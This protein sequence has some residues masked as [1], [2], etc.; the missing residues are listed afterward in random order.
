M[1]KSHSLKRPACSVRELLL[2]Y[3][4]L[5]QLRLVKRINEGGLKS[6]SRSLNGHG[7]LRTLEILV[8]IWFWLAYFVN[9]DNPICYGYV[10][11]HLQETIFVIAQQINEK[12]RT[13][14]LRLPEICKLDCICPKYCVDYT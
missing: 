7:L 14:H 3:T 11:K 8:V 9:T 5:L 4:V 13:R 10:C 6:A 12:T 2:T 1:S